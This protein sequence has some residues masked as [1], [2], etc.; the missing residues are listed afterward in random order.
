MKNIITMALILIH[1][2]SFG[3]KNGMSEFTSNQSYTFPRISQTTYHAYW[4]AAIPTIFSPNGD[5]N[6]D[7]W[8]VKFRSL[9]ESLPVHCSHISEDNSSIYAYTV[10]I[11]DRWGNNLLFSQSISKPFTDTQGFTGEEITWDGT[12]N[13]QPVAQGVYLGIITTSSCFNAPFRCT[14]C[15]LHDPFQYCYGRETE[16]GK[17]YEDNDNNFATKCGITVVR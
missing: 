6:N 11:Y 10:E 13:G 7:L 9:D 5:G 17:P 1:F 14:D 2:I 3:Q 16:C 4:K 15:D 8:H 12:F